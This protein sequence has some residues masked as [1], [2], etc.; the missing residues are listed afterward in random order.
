LHFYATCYSYYRAFVMPFAFPKLRVT[1]YYGRK[2]IVTAKIE[3]T[4]FLS[5]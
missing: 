2:D 1:M 5:T 4:P 3:D